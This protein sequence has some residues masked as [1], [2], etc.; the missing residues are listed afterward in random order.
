[1]AEAVEH[2]LDRGDADARRASLDELER[3]RDGPDAPRRL[4]A[5]APAHG[6]RDRAY[7]VDGRAARRV[8]ARR[9]RDEVR[10]RVGDRPAR[11][12][13]LVVA[14]R[15]GLHHDLEH[16]GAWHGRADRLDLLAHLVETT[17]LRE[18]DVDH[19]VDLLRAVGDRLPRL[20]NLDL[21]AAVARGEPDRRADQDP[22]GSRHR[23]DV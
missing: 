11:L 6:V 16:D 15:G 10:P 21:G 3:L 12:D 23:H 17:L 22:L 2:S 19:E 1:G 14:Q 18:A 13:E 8:H 9:R 4:D 5:Y 20:G 7:G